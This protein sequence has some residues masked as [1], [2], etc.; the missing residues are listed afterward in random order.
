VTSTANPPGSALF[1]PT[2]R[3]VL[4]CLVVGL[5]GAVAALVFEAL[6]HGAQHLLLQGIGG[7]T[8]PATGVLDPEVSLPLWSERWWIPVA[9]TLGG[10]LSGFIVY[11]FAP[12]AEGHGT[13]AAIAAYHQH[14]AEVRPRI[15]FI[16]AVTSALTIGS[17][18]VAGREGPT[19]QIAVG[20]GAIFGRVMNL[21][22]QER[23]I[24]L[25]ASM[26]AGLA[27]MFQAPLGMAIFAVEILYAGMV[28]ESEA[29]VYTVISAVTAYAVHGFFRGWTPLFAIPSG[30][31]LEH[32]VELLGYVV[33]GVLAGIFGAL[34]PS[35][36]FKTRDLFR[37]LP[38][39]PHIRPAIGGLLVGLAGAVAPPVL[40]TGYGWVE[41]ALAGKLTVGLLVLLLLVKGPAMALTIG[42][43][44]SGGVFAPTITLGGLLGAGVAFGIG[45]LLPELGIH[46]NISGPA[47]IVVGMAAV[48]A[49]AARVPISTLIMV[50]EMTTGYGLIVPTML[51]VTVAFLVQRSI[52]RGWRYPTLYESQVEM[53]E[54]SP[55]HRG[56]F[57][58]RALSM[59]EGGIVERRDLT[60]PRLVN[61]L[62]YGD[63]IPVTGQGGMLSALRIGE[64]SQLAGRTVAESVGKI[65]GVT[66]VA[67]LRADEMLIPRGP[68]LLEA[69][70]QLIAVAELPGYER[71]RQAAGQEEAVHEEAG[72][73]EETGESPRHE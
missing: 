6:V 13:D 28:F 52:T 50:V 67:V 62:R 49:G 51:A 69:G 70:D 9:T 22:G 30:L 31:V 26:A 35:L 14:G 36:L 64:G 44:G 12:E 46:V 1:S 19:A 23:R 73:E 16:K 10:L 54:D 8:P 48:F 40:G 61:L 68:T 21:R 45:H 60:L 55:A 59:L 42:S 65:P 15:P 57:V 33:L 3:L 25:L 41:L 5:F 18:G 4:Y 43:G 58:R 27:A 56:V 53:R 34:L 32:P 2:T 47:F 7:Y 63:P 66:A 39:P 20:L 17:G 38:G 71:L 37:R 29:L 72:Q 24:L 11:R